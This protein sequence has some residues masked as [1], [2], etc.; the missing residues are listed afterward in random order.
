M[1]EK[2]DARIKSLEG[3]L[4]LAKTE[5][6]KVLREKDKAVTEKEGLVQEVEERRKELES[7]R[8]ALNNAKKES[9]GRVKE[10]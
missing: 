1:N 2:L 3:E 7:A 5:G 8:I 9:Q 4:T 6:E 10:R